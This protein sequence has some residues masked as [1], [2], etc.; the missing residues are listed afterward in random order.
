MWDTSDHRRYEVVDYT[1][2]RLL[3]NYRSLEPRAGVYVFADR[4]HQVRYVGKAGP[5][6]MVDEVADAI[7]RGKDFGA[8]EVKALYTNS[9]EKAANLEKY[10]IEKYQPPNNR[11]P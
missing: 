8:T 2:W 9:N 6:R 5:G 3:K 4:N 10:L 11:R 7:A 1:N